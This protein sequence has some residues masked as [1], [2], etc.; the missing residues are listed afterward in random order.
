M[1]KELLKKVIAFAGG[2][3]TGYLVTGYVAQTYYRKQQKELE[4]EN[5]RL[6]VTLK[7]IRTEAKKEGREE[8]FDKKVEGYKINMS[9]KVKAPVEDAE[10]SVENFENAYKQALEVVERMKDEKAK[11]E[12]I[13][14]SDI[15]TMTY[16][17]YQEAV[18]EDDFEVLSF[19][20]YTKADIIL[21]DGSEIVSEDEALEILGDAWKGYFEVDIQEPDVV[22]VRNAKRREYIEVVRTYA[23]LHME[24]IR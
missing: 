16:T 17:D 3:V 22:Y 19:T 10:K 14:S 9:K 7:L 13:P 24:H 11:R 6:R 21:D 8:E 2:V 12:E 20:W 18:K 15:S 23:P 5:R 4:D 1:N